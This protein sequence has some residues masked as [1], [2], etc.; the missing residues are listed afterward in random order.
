MRK[1]ISCLLGF[2]FLL[3]TIAIPSTVLAKTATIPSVDIVGTIRKDGT[4]HFVEKRTIQFDGDFTYGY[5][6]L[7]KANFGQIDGFKISDENQTFTQDNSMS[8]SPGTYYTEDQGDDTRVYYYF[9]ARNVTKTFTIEFTLRDNIQIYEDYGQLYWKLQGAGW[10]FEIDSFK[11]LM[12]WESS[13]PKDNYWIWAHGVLWGNFE[14]TD[15]VSATLEVLDVPKKSFVEI[16]MLLPTNYFAV[17]P[18]QAGTIYEK[19]V[20][21]ETKWADEANAEREEAKEYMEQQKIRREKLKKTGQIV[22]ILIYLVAFGL[23]L[24]LVYLYKKYGTEFIVPNEAIYYREPPSDLRPAL[25]GMLF[26][27]Q[28]YSDTFLQATILDLIRRKWIQY[29]EIEG[30]IFTRDY[31]MTKLDNSTDPLSD[32]ERTL[33]DTI[34]FDE[35][36]IIRI[37][38]LKKKF[39]KKQTHYY[40]KFQDFVNQVK[41]DSKSNEYFDSKSNGISI[42][43]LVLGILML[44]P[45]FIFG[46]SFSIFFFGVPKLGFLALAPVGLAYLFSYNALKRRTQKGKE[47]FIKWKA[48]RS[49]MKDFSNLKEYGP[50]SLIIW[51]QFLV[52]A[53]VFGIAS[54]VL[55]AL[56]VVAPTLSDTG[57]GTFLGPNYFMA[58]A[59]PSL[60]GLQR[61]LSSISNAVNTIPKTAASSSSS[62]FGGGGGFSGGG[63]GGGGGSGGGFG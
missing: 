22:Q 53:T 19:V 28:K 45:S 63:G 58:G 26:N 59:A 1:K 43:V 54:V 49:F 40:Y 44:F 9:E 29:E 60:A 52:Y 4:V 32:F 34:L 35:A 57:N 61:S 55:R 3:M 42:L 36:S 5:Y 6:N 16:R 46:V 38:E 41:A 25:A 8:K 27:F 14:K 39:N 11:A 48:F 21:E 17:K 50:K 37:K 47:E 7:P 33:M 62:G 24:L 2:L 15:D 10:D 56:K 31:Q 18:N 12:K 23:L 51:E 20:A 30:N 13:I